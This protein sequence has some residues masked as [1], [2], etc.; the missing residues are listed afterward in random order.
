MK[1]WRSVGV[2]VLAGMLAGGCGWAQVAG[3]MHRG[4]NTFPWM[5]RA[6]SVDGKGE[7]FVTEG[8]FPN[9]AAYTAE[10]LSTL[11]AMG[12]DFLRM[13]VE[14]TPWL[15][16]ADAGERAKFTAQLMTAVRTAHGAGLRVIVA[17]FPREVIPQWS[18]DSI[19]KSAE[20]TRLW[21][22][23]LVEMAGALAAE[24][25]AGDVLET[26]NEPSG[27]YNAKDEHRWADLQA[28]Y[29]KA[30][31]KV[32]PTLTVLVTGDRGGGVDG[33]LRL[34]PGPV[35]DAHVLYTFHY[36]DPMV[37]THQGAKSA[38]KKYRPLL[39]GIT[40]PPVGSE[41]AGTLERTHAAVTGE[42]G[43][44]GGGGEG[45]ER[46]GRPD[47]AVLRDAAGEGEDRRRPGEGEGVGEVAPHCPGTAGAGG[48]RG[49]AAGCLCGDG[50]GV[51]TRCA[52]GGGARGIC[53]V[54]L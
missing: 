52:D 43:G 32:A 35:E 16:T 15:V 27:G 21:G 17:P 30:V 12:F 40:Y 44:S 4:T 45:V 20:K 11:R 2:G 10:R 14:P 47:P 37:M 39:S 19:L 5:Y 33:L 26:M 49:V 41:E 23:M 53:V 54:L 3:E 31:R 36:Y 24:K 34:D 50:R 28:G 51:D 42:C 29:V 9:M 48:V 7:V 13:Q 6:R 1:L 46:G 22:G 25:N 38:T 18:A 8:T